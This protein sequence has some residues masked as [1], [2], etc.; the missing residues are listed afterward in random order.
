MIRWKLCKA[1]RSSE[2]V[3]LL[4]IMRTFLEPCSLVF[5]SFKS[6]AYDLPDPAPFIASFS[7]FYSGFITS[8]DF[9]QLQLFCCALL[10]SKA[11]LQL[12]GR[13]VIDPPLI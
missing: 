10:F 7:Y 11:V 8:Y 5:H 3:T 4:Q 9:I 6:P 12:I 2:N 13:M 1:L